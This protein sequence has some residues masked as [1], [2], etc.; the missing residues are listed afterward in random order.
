VQT[1]TS[2]NGSDWFRLTSGMDSS[3]GIICIE[4][5]KDKLFNGSVVK[6]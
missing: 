1:T 3:T 5:D 6:L 4:L 2:D